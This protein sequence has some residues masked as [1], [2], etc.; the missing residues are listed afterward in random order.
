MQELVAADEA[1]AAKAAA[2]AN[3]IKEDCE[4]DLAEALPALK[5]ALKALDTLKPSD[6]GEVKAM[7]NPPAGV[8]LVMSAVC[9]MKGQKPDRVKDPGGSGKMV[10][11]YWGPSKRLL[12]DLKFLQVSVS[13]DIGCSS[14]SAVA[15]R[16]RQ[17]QYSGQDHEGYPG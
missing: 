1:V 4:A 2:E 6:I 5:N 3:A 14:R 16:L 8:K 13:L 9:V 11:D 7:K 15:Q 17:R 12:G 10:E